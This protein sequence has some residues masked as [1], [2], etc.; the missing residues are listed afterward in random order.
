MEMTKYAN[1]TA[2]VAPE[3]STKKTTAMLGINETGFAAQKKVFNALNSAGS[4]ADH[5]TETGADTFVCE[6]VILQTKDRTDV[7]TGEVVTVQ[8]A[9]FITPEGGFYSESVGIVRSA[10]NFIDACG[11]VFPVGEIVRFKIESVQLDSKRTMKQLT[12]I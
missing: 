4:L 8:G 5:M 3:E 12:L 11:G 1:E 6:G 9:T 7:V 2:I 10:S